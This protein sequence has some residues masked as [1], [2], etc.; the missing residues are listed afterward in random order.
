M[1]NGSYC[2]LILPKRKASLRANMISLSIHCSLTAKFIFPTSSFL[3]DFDFTLNY[4]SSR[5]I[6]YQSYFKLDYIVNEKARDV[7]FGYWVFVNHK[8]LKN[9]DSVDLNN[10]K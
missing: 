7:L 9:R 5:F 6:L 3:I 8:F 1:L 4:S 10:I 2:L